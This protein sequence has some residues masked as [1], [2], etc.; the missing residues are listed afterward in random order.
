MMG[1]ATGIILA[2]FNDLRLFG[3]LVGSAAIPETADHL[4]TGLLIGGG[5]GPIHV[6]IRFVSERKVPYVQSAGEEKKE[7]PAPSSASEKPGQATLQGAAA[8]SVAISPSVELGAWRDISYRGGVDPDVLESIHL[9]GNDPDLI[10]YHHTAMNSSSTFDDVVR[11]IKSREDSHG[12]SWVTGYNCVVTYDGVIHP[13]CRWDRYGN[14]AAG[15]NRRSLGVAFNGN[16]EAN[17]GVPYSNANGRYG[18]QRPSDEQLGPESSRSG[19][20][21]MVS[22]P[23]SMA[24]SSLTT[25]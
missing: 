22:T 2:A 25:R 24:R 21:S 17:P 12:N 5:S 13:F 15:S 16:F 7:A 9:R 19:L 23:T 4:L 18:A 14:H 3:S 20:I 8:P 10:V 6:L 11:V 1:L